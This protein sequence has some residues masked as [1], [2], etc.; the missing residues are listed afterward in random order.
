MLNVGKNINFWRKFIKRQI[1]CSTEATVHLESDVIVSA[2]FLKVK[3]NLRSKFNLLINL[4]SFWT[5]KS[6]SPAT[7]FSSQGSTFYI[8]FSLDSVL[9][10]RIES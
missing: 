7:D 8:I 9:K 3:R 4:N 10:L 6:I 2:C 5:E 1:T